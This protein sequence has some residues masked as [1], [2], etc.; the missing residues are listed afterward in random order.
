MT[1]AESLGVADMP[2]VQVPH[3]MG[4]IPYD[5]IRA[6]ADIVFPEILKAATEWVPERN[7][8]PGVGETAYPAEVV[9]YTGS[10]AE[11]N[12]MMFEQGWSLGIPVVPPTRDLVDEM[13]TGTSHAPDEILWEGIPPRMGVLTVEVAAADAVMA[14]CKPEVFPLLLAV[15]EA[16]QAEGHNW[17]SYTTTT[18]PTAPLVIVSGP[19]VKELGIGYYSEGAWGV[20]AMG[21][22]YPTNLCIGHFVNLIGDVVGGSV[23][24]DGDKST[25]GWVAN[26]IASVVG[27][28]GDINPWGETYAEEKGFAPTDNVVTL[29]GGPPPLVENDHASV[30]PQDL[31]EVMAY[32]M[33]SVGTTRCLGSGGIWMLSYEHAETLAHDGWTKDDVRQFLYEKAVAPYWSMPPLSA[34]GKS[35][36]TSCLPPEDFGPVTDDTM[37]PAVRSPEMIEFVIAGGG[38]KQGMFWPIVFGPSPLVSVLIEPWE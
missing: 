29:H 7:T 12:D 26:T 19:I 30:R 18:Y 28:I 9:K 38:G 10:Y 2:M 24:P 34:E 3:P 6:K 23:I 14:G 4:M 1:S 37:I 5:E 21:P 13:L 11:L 8:I 35:V 20:G 31:A 22:G 17:K 15:V 25:H 16:M 36:T 27:E 32:T 33:N